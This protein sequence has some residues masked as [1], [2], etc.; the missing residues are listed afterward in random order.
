MKYTIDDYLLELKQELKGND[1]AIIQDALADAH[2]HLTTALQAAVEEKPEADQDGLLTEIIEQY[3]SPGETAAAYREIES[4]TAV[5]YTTSRVA[6]EPKNAMA[7]FFAI[8]N[9]S[10]AW[11]G[12]LYMLISIL[13]GIVYFDWVL[14]AASVTLIFILVLSFFFRSIA[15]FYLL[16]VDGLAILEGRLVEALLQIRMPRRP[17]LYPKDLPW[18]ERLKHQLSDKGTWKKLAYMILMLPLGVIYF[19][20]IIF[21]IA[22]SLVGIT[23]PLVQEAFNLP[24][25]TFASQAYFLPVY[26]YPITVLLGTLL[27]TLTLHLAKGIGKMHGRFAKYMLVE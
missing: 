17:L 6:K 15:T 23:V 1:K 19:T 3:G 13:L 22:F 12:M 20:V 27:F 4:R 18:K 14:I 25:F 26:S 5:S 16:S 24:S 2:E 9:D 11:G 10:S 7:A 8:Y 21:L